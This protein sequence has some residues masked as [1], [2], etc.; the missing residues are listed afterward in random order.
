MIVLAMLANEI[1]QLKQHIERKM[2]HKYVDIYIQRPM[3]NDLTLELLYYA[4]DDITSEKKEVHAHITATILVQT[5]LNAHELVR[6]DEFPLLADEEK[7]EK[8]LLVLAG[9]YYS[10]LYYLLLSEIQDVKMVNVLAKGIQEV[11]EKKMQ[12]Y[13]SEYNSLDEFIDLLLHI[14]T[15]II[16]GVSRHLFQPT[17]ANIIKNI[18]RLQFLLQE[19]HQESSLIDFHLEHQ[20]VPCKEEK[21]QT[22][23]T[24]IHEHVQLIEKDLLYID[25]LPHAFTRFVQ[26]FLNDEVYDISAA[27][28]G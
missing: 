27:E 28:E 7:K 21:V 9:D 14:H 15:T 12:L 5:A 26:Y 8:Q 25:V 10:G 3:I 22:I 11:N 4:M 13:Y 2:N 23:R 1:N 6:N 18:V 24:R 17:V 16:T 20:T 19:V